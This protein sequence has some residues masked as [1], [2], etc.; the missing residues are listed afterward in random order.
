VHPDLQD[1]LD[2]GRLAR[3][4]PL[5]HEALGLLRFHHL[6]RKAFVDVVLGAVN[7]PLR[8][9]AVANAS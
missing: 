9:L 1:D 8:P 6:G 5:E 3:L 2:R 4:A 7:H